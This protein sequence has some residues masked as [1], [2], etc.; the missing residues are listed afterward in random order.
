MRLRFVKTR[1]RAQRLIAEGLIRVDGKRCTKPD[2][3]IDV[4]QTLTLPLPA[5]VTVVRILTLPERRGPAAEARACY[6][7]LC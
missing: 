3:R 4:G 6:E 5:G 1:G 7:T 2:A